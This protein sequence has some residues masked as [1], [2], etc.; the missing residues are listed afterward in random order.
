MLFR[1]REL[2]QQL[3]AQKVV[4]VLDTNTHK[5]AQ[6]VLTLLQNGTD[7]ATLA[8]QVSADTTTKSNGGQFGF[9]IDKGSQTV[10]PQTINALFSLKPGQTSDV[11]NIGY[12]LEIDKVLSAQGTKIQAAHIV[13][14]FSDINSYLNPLKQKEKTHTFIKE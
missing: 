4:S 9:S 11:I 7:F 3:L 1:S 10:P 13:L 8:G 2:K 6:D 14:N 5:R 12:G